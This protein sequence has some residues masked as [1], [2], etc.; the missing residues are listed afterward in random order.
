MKIFF[1]QAAFFI[2]YRFPGP[3]PLIPGS[4]IILTQLA[5]YTVRQRILNAI[6]NDI[7]FNIKHSFVTAYK[8]T[9]LATYSKLSEIV[10]SEKT[11]ISVKVRF[12]R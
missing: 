5:A 11:G 12:L 4:D 6:I 8:L 7:I 2:R 9:Q 10:K 1:N 3:I